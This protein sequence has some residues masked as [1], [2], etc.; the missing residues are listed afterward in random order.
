MN[1][2]GISAE[3]VENVLRKHWSRVANTDG[4]S[5]EYMAVE[6][7]PGINATAVEHAALTGGVSLEEQTAAAYEEIE[8]QLVWQGVLEELRLEPA[9]SSN[10]QGLEGETCRLVTDP[11]A[12]LPA[13]V[14]RALMDRF[15]LA[16]YQAGIFDGVP[17]EERDLWFVA[18]LANE[19]RFDVE[20]AVGITGKTELEAM[21][22]AVRALELAA[23]VSR[24]QEPA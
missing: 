7:F 16:V 1:A 5:F 22:E 6:L 12:E 2:F 4:N 14:V 3:D 24:V 20:K 8:R 15:D 18:P 23:L 10:P 11:A 21:R 13:D 19:T 17:V 9:A